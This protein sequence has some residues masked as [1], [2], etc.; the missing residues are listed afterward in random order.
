VPGADGA[1]RHDS[2]EE[3]LAMARAELRASAP[4]AATAADAEA[5]LMRLLTASLD[6]I[7][8]GHLRR[9]AGLM[10]ALPTRGAPN[11]DYLMWHAGMDQAHRYALRGRL[12]ESERVGI[13]LYTI[14][15]TGAALL[16]SYAVHDRT[17]TE[18]SGEFSLDI[19]AGLAGPNTL[20]L[21]P[22]TRVLLIRV[23]HR[24]AG[25]ACALTLT[26]GP[27]APRFPSVALA[28]EAVLVQAAQSALRAVRLFLN[29]TRVTSERPNCIL[30]PPASMAAEVQGDPDTLYGLGYFQLEPGQWL[31]A[32]IPAG[33]YAYWSLHAYN[34]WCEA[35]PGAGT[36]DLRALPDEDGRTRVR[37]GVAAPAS[38]CNRLDT[39]G[40]Q[41]GALVFR[42]LGGDT[43][44][45]PEVKLRG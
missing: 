38:L 4:D 42:A 8:L 27:P 18:R 44:R 40:R 37:I 24:T 34:H 16:R 31:E 23:L 25:L 20:T 15:P 41:R 29:W 32:L 14:G 43:A 39:L 17:T 28:G 22:E 33:R 45:L 10:R 5:Y 3:L 12:H 2:V 36:H 11:P 1:A 26:G 6:D 19:G 35:L 7:Y 13:G 21:T 30:A 9:E